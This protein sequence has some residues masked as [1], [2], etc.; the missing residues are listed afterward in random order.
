MGDVLVIKCNYNL[1][2]RDLDYVR[3]TFVNQKAQGVVLL[4]LGFEAVVVPDDIEVKIEGNVVEN[5][6]D[7]NGPGIED[8]DIHKGWKPYL[9]N[10]KKGELR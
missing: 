7:G 1:S 5:N 10:G 6:I 4:P 9:Y 2:I 3:N 8:F